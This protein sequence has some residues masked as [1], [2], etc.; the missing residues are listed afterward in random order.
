MLDY[1]A[2]KFTNI[3]DTSMQNNGILN[4]VLNNTPRGVVLTSDYLRQH[5][6]SAKLAW[7]YVH[8]NWLEHLDGKAYRRVN[9]KLSWGSLLYT[10]QS[11]HQLNIHVSGRTAIAMS[12]KSHYLYLGDDKNIF[13]AVG[14]N[15]KVP[16][17]FERANFIPEKFSLQKLVLLYDENIQKYLMLTELD[18]LKISY[19]CNELAILEVLCTCKT[20]HDYEEASQLM[21]SFPYLR[22]VIVQ[23]LLEQS[24]SIIATRLY[25]HLAKLHNHSWYKKLDLSKFNLGSGKRRIGA[26][27]LYDKD[28]QL[29]VPIN[30]G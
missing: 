23:K 25:L 10:L 11:I 30:Q 12:G 22:S 13:V 16:A 8:S 7:W 9:D 27:K 5:G 3:V 28:V 15:V 14:K 18:G 20:E 24:N 17:W 1:L 21:E 29:Y 2:I 26:G 4:S 19:S 6:V